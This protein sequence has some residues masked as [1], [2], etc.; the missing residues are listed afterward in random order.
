MSKTC[1]YRLIEK[2]T[3][4]LVCGVAPPSDQD[5]GQLASVMGK[6][7]HDRALVLSLGG[8]PSAKQRKQLMDAS[9]GRAAQIPCAI[10]TD[11]VM[12]RGITT[13]I[14]WFVPE[15]RSFRPEEIEPALQY[16]RVTTPASEV[17]K[18]IDELKR[19]LGSNA[20]AAHAP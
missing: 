10:L 6:N 19:E 14:S 18:V 16:L 9:H 2:R 17:R 4:I 3:M 11:S 20:Y 12:V 15:V 1:V 8:G 7:L 5:W 13:A